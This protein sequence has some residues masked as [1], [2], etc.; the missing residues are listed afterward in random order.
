[1]HLAQGWGWR[2]GPEPLFCGWQKTVD[3]QELCLVIR[4][5]TVEGEI[6]VEINEDIGF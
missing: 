2:R 4:P 6:V 5:G 3:D 1:M